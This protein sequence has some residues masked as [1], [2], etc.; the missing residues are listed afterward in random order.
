MGCPGNPGNPG[1]CL[2]MG[3]GGTFRSDF[4]REGLPENVWIL[5]FLENH[6]STHTQAGGLR[7]VECRL[8]N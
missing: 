8:A 4:S 7:S 6:T 5:P 3:E 1:P 2:P